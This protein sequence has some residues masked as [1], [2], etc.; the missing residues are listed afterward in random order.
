M[1]DW[2][3]M[4]WMAGQITARFF[5]ERGSMRSLKDSSLIM[6]RVPLLLGD[7]QVKISQDWKLRAWLFRSAFGEYDHFLTVLRIGDL[8]MLG[9]P[10]DFSGEFSASLDSTARR[11]NLTSIVTS[12]NG[13]YI[14]YVTPGKYYDINH[15]ETRLMNWYA[16]GTGEY[17]RTCLEKLMIAASDTN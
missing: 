6:K 17:I 7:P 1:N 9:A 15:Y 3:C 14:G 8:V 13:G 2:D 11:H 4:D 16:P 5:A 10:C 12:F